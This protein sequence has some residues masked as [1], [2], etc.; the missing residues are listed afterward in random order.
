MEKITRYEA[1]KAL[2]KGKTVK[3]THE[4]IHKMWKSSSLEDCDEVDG[5]GDAVLKYLFEQPFKP[6][7]DYYE[8]VQPHV[9][10][11]EFISELIDM[12]SIVK[13]NRDAG[14]QFNTDAV[15][16]LDIME[17]NMKGFIRG[18]RFCKH[19]QQKLIKYL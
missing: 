18:N 15:R 13:K 14:G 8:E 17:F 2:N 10:M 4:L 11:D 9:Q 1:F 7:R 19:P 5:T 3:E 16:M 12:L 6:E